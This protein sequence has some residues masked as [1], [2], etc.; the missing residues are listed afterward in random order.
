MILKP[1]MTM[2][3]PKALVYRRYTAILAANTMKTVYKTEWERN[4]T[5]YW[6][7]NKDDMQFTMLE[8]GVDTSE[9]DIVNVTTGTTVLEYNYPDYSTGEKRT[10]YFKFLDYKWQ[11]TTGGTNPILAQ[12]GNV[13]KYQLNKYGFAGSFDYI[14]SSDIECATTQIVKGNIVPLQSF[15]IK[16]YS[17]NIDLR[18]DDLVVIESRLYSVENPTMSHNHTP[19]DY[20]VYSATLNSVL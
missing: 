2:G 15:T 12:F 16:Y 7:F 9:S 5:A 19:R 14:I 8:S 20:K 10:K 11:E 18:P 6:L 3:N 17:D 1:K 4:T 13:S